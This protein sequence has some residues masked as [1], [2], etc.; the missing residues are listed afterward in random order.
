MRCFHFAFFSFCFI[1]LVPFAFIFVIFTRVFSSLFSRSMFHRYVCAGEPLQ[2]RC[3]ALM[4]FDSGRVKLVFFRPVAKWA[5]RTSVTWRIVQKATRWKCSNSSNFVN[6]NR[7]CIDGCCVRPKFVD[8]PCMTLLRRLPAPST[9]CTACN[10]KNELTQIATFWHF[11]TR[12]LRDAMAR[13]ALT[14]KYSIE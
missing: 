9:V 2:T 12:I 3:K 10:V 13:Q 14:R 11:A 6:V 7:F 5:V 1:S 4:H 8:C